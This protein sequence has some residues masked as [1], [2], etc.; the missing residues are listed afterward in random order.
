MVVTVKMNKT[1]GSVARR[2]SF[3]AVMLEKLICFSG[4]GAPTAA[5]ITT[6]SPDNTYEN[7]KFQE[8]FEHIVD[9]INLPTHLRGYIRYSR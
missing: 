4:G 1:H 2:A 8:I 5:R 9:D 6:E 7:K 3:G